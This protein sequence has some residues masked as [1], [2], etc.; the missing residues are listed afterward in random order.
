[1]K[2]ENKKGILVLII[3]LLIT[4][5]AF[6]IIGFTMRD[7]EKP[8]EVPENPN[9]EFKYMGFLYFYEEDNLLGTYKCENPDG[10]CGFA[11]NTIDDVNFPL[12]HYK[13]A[14]NSQIDIVN[15]RFVF[16]LDYSH[17]A[18]TQD[19]NDF[20]DR[21]LNANI[22]LYDIKDQKIIAEYQAVKNYGIG[23][24]YNRFIVQLIES[25]NWGV[26]ELN[27]TISTI[28]DFNYQFIGLIDK[29]IADKLSSE[30]F[31][32]M[33]DN[34]WFLVNYTGNEIS[35][36]LDAPIVDF[37]TENIITKVNYT[38]YLNNY[39][40]RI[41]IGIGYNNLFFVDRFIAILDKNNMFYVYDARNN[42]DITSR[43]STENGLTY[44]A[45]IN[46]E[47]NLVVRVGAS[48]S[49]YQINI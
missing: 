24:E 37:T 19:P 17:S 29:I 23:I 35:T 20:S 9:R 2:N 26:I 15:N 47:G 30:V 31:V 12:R 14:E 40:G 46:A 25:N 5:S 39:Q 4:S 22:I 18:L 21:P 38:Y 41:G 27:D 42:T 10:Y 8:R 33:R 43:L 45:R 16:L 34:Q 3:I 49:T 48:I 6:G 36:G 1:M 7:K 28:I 44:D 32:T 11:Y 13:D